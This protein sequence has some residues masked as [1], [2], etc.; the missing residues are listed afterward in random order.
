[1]ITDSGAKLLVFD[2]E[3]DAHDYAV[4][5]ELKQ[6]KIKKVKNDDEP[7]VRISY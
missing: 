4:A 5:L 2:T 7:R 1:M 6:F 3:H